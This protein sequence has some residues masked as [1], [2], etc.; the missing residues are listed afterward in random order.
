[1]RAV[2][3]HISERQSRIAE[4]HVF[5]GLQQDGPLEQ[6]LAF[7]PR[8]A[9]WVM[10]FQDV[11]RLNAQRMQDP[12]LAMLMLRHRQEERGHDNWFF[13][14]AAQLMG[15][16]FKLTEPWSRG[17]EAIRDASYSIL[18]EVMRPLDDKLRIVL[19]LTLE[20]TSHAFF[21]RTSNLPQTL[22]Q[23]K[24]LKYFSNH[25]MEA[26][27]QHEVFE[28][29]MEAMLLGMELSPELHAEAIALVDRIYAAFHSMF[30]GLQAEQPLSA[31]PPELH[32]R[33]AVTAKRALAAATP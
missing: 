9:F 4:H 26:E 32:K 23:G 31:V 29:Q 17:H 24:R 19:V 25:H 33:P 13:E 10:S 6:V 2:L 21:S 28:E 15:R 7:A 20:S 12:E 1:M 16:P 5:D 14:D 18:A 11:L 8:L 27:E 30:D 3:N 22:S